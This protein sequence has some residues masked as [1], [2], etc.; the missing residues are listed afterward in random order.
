MNYERWIM[1][2]VSVDYAASI[3]RINCVYDSYEHCGV[4]ILV[5]QVV[6]IPQ[7]LSWL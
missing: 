7:H 2:S 6:Y 5:E 3:R 1:T 4:V